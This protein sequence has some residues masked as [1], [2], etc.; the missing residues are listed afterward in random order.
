[1]KMLRERIEGAWNDRTMLQDEKVKR[2]VSNVI[3]LLD[4][5]KLRVAEKA[6]T[7]EWQTNEWIKKAVLLYFA[8]M[9]MEKM[10]AGPMIFHDK[11]PLKRNYKKLGVRVVPHG[12]ARFGAYLAKGVIM[13]P[14]Y[15]NIGAYIDEGHPGGHVD[16]SRIVR[17]DRKECSSKRRRGI[18]GVVGTRS[19]ESSNR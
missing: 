13:M 18:G 12:I 14:S 6:T 9:P 4:Q 15:V 19:G 1:M 8:I 7:G 3:E 16:N 11:I 10:E 17:T 5:G 2:A